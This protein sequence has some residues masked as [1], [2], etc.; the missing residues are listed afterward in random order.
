[1][2]LRARTHHMTRKLKTTSSSS[3]GIS[4]RSSMRHSVC[5]LRSRTGS[6]GRLPNSEGRSSLLDSEC[7]HPH[8]GYARLIFLHSIVPVGTAVQIPTWARALCHFVWLMLVLI[9]GPV[10]RDARYFSPHPNKFWPERW[11]PDE[12]PKIAEARGED[13]RLVHGAYMP[14]NYGSSPRSLSGG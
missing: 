6:S 11:L 5:S 10:H 7:S 8:A 3:L 9:I 1:M 13:F 12:G 14:F 2:R 4:R